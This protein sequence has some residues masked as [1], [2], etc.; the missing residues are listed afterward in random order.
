MNFVVENYVKKTN[1]WE[2]L[3][4]YILQLAKN[5][6]MSGNDPSDIALKWV[7]KRAKE[8]L[9]DSKA[10]EALDRKLRDYRNASMNPETKGDN[11]F[12]NSTLYPLLYVLGVCDVMAVQDFCRNVLH[13]DELSARNL[14]DFLTLSCLQ[15]RCTKEQY[16]SLLDKYSEEIKHMPLAP[17]TFKYGVT[18][19]HLGEI[20]NFSSVEQ[21]TDY[22][23]MH[24]HEFAKTRNTRYVML[25]DEV[26]WEEW[27]DLDWKDFFDQHPEYAIPNYQEMSTGE[28]K[29]YIKTTRISGIS[30]SMERDIIL[31]MG[32]DK[33]SIDAGYYDTDEGRVAAKEH[34]RKLSEE[35]QG[36]YRTVKQRKSLLDCYHRFRVCDHNGLTDNQI[37]ALAE[38]EDYN[39]AF[40]SFDAFDRMFHQRRKSD[41]PFGV[42]LLFMLQKYLPDNFLSEESVQSA[43]LS[44]FERDEDNTVIKMNRVGFERFFTSS[45]KFIE[46]CN[47]ELSL[48]GYPSLSRYN[49]FAKLFLDTYD[50]ICKEHPEMKRFS[51]IRALF[52]NRL[53]QHLKEIADYYI[54]QQSK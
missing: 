48:A 14:D 33:I 4:N 41:I 43:T 31:Y 13:Q 37:N 49:L 7:R 6:A 29:D 53:C 18:G 35:Y 25:F 23:N 27:I 16:D 15:L 2:D 54:V 24:I 20:K 40:L 50:E 46:Q 26:D 45:D 42:Y 17:D 32:Y 47:W 19:E 21:L 5:D 34:R 36:G 28:W 22:I 9:S 3:R 10:C 38:Q 8:Q 52:I 30:P 11:Y 44:L 1:S 39:K 51:E 12:K